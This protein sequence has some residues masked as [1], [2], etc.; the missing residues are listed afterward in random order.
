MFI[1]RG[2]HTTGKI[3]TNLQIFFVLHMQNDPS[4]NI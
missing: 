3:N 2:E 1:Y 4:Q